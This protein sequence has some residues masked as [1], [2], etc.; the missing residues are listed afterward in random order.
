M[1]APLLLHHDSSSATNARSSSESDGPSTPETTP[2]LPSTNAWKTSKKRSS[3]STTSNPSGKKRGRRAIKR[4]STERE[5]YE[6]DKR[7]NNAVAAAKSRVKKADQQKDLL[8]RSH[9]LGAKNAELIQTLENLKME[10]A[11]TVQE[12]KTHHSSTCA[13]GLLDSLA[14]Q[15]QHIIQT[16]HVG[17]M[18][19]DIV[20]TILSRQEEQQSVHEY[21]TLS[22]ASPDASQ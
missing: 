4:S 1:E 16:D 9:A 19:D 17:L 10:L 7:A 12:V 2:E 21:D 3:S 8:A 22:E 11:L 20:N 6:K 15:C 5:K 13:E 14:T 18:R